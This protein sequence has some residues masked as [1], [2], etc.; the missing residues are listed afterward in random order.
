[1]VQCFTKTPSSNKHTTNH[2]QN[3]IQP[4]KIAATLY[5]CWY[6][7]TKSLRFGFLFQLALNKLV[8]ATILR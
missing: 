3:L 7:E 6:Y 4:D 8:S 5:I 2:S 1:M